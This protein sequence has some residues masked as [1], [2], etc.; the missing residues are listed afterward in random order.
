ME[1][2]PNCGAEV[3]EE[4]EETG[5]GPVFW[6]VQPG[7]PFCS[8]EC[9]VMMHELYILSGGQIVNFE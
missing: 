8:G 6:K 7:R 4:D 5:E 9:V 2:C 3:P 1:R